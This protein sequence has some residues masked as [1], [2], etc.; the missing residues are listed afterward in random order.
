MCDELVMVAGTCR[1][2]AIVSVDFIQPPRMLERERDAPLLWLLVQVMR[3]LR[4]GDCKCILSRVLGYRLPV[5][6]VDGSRFYFSAMLHRAVVVFSVN[7]GEL[8]GE[9]LR[10]YTFLGVFEDASAL[11]LSFI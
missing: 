6:L 5:V 4:C 3:R 2:S 8:L 11:K 9:L 10:C 7:V 1:W